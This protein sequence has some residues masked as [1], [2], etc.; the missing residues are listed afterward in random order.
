MTIRIVGLL[1]GEDTPFDGKYVKS[2]DP[3]FELEGH[4]YDGGILEVTDDIREAMV[5]T[6]MSAAIAK[7]RQS[8]G[9]R[10]DGQPN[11]P[12]T[13]WSVEFEEGLW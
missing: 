3:T 1:T 6:D 13:A 4:P 2:Y 8:H 9:I 10:A 11:R 7:Y 5:F 12:L